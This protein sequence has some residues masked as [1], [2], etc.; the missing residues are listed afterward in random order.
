MVNISLYFFPKRVHVM[1]ENVKISQ[2]RDF[3]PHF[4][5]GENSCQCYLLPCR[6][7]F[8]ELLFHSLTGCGKF[9][10][11]IAYLQICR[12]NLWVWDIFAGY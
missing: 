7:I 6:V 9:Q 3:T 12:L 1:K 4:G 5:N 8:A 2:E 10:F 11:K